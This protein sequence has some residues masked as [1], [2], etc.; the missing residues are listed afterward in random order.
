MLEAQ[1]HY[2]GPADAKQSP[3]PDFKVGDQVYLRAKYLCSTRPSKKH[4]E[5]YLGPFIII[6]KPGTHSFTLQLPD[7]MCSVHPV[8]YVSQLEPCAPNTI[9]NH[10]QPPAPPIE[11]NGK[12]KYKIKEILDSKINQRRHHCQLLYLVCW[13]S[14]QGTDDKTSWLLAMELGNAKELVADFHRR[15]PNKPRPLPS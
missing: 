12:P 2:Q 11:V 9:P 13:L 1:K 5:K 15:Y 8:F 7:S 10:V 14:Y 6:S 4:S 3:A